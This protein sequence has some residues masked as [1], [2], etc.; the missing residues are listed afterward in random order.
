M[1]CFDD[2]FIIKMYLK[3]FYFGIYLRIL[4]KLLLKIVKFFKFVFWFKIIEILKY[5]E[6]SLRI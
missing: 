3:I 2:L 5:M 1:I 6:I 4:E